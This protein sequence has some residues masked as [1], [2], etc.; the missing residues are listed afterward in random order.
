MAN[1]AKKSGTAKADVY[2]LV[3]EKFIEALK[4]GLIPWRKPWSGK[5]SGDGSARSYESGLAYS[6]LNQW[7]IYAQAEENCKGIE[8]EAARRERV[9]KISSGRFITFGALQKIEGSRII[10]GSKSYLVTFYKPY[11]PIDKETGKPAVVIDEDG[12]ERP[13]IIPMLKY[14]RVFSEFDCTGLPAE[15][16]EAVKILDP[17]AEAERVINNYVGRENGGPKFHADFGDKAFYSPSGD[18]VQVPR[19]EQYKQ[20]AEYYST[21]FHELVHST[22]HSSRCAREG[23]DK[24][25]HFGDSDY[26]REEL[27]AE[28]GA[29]MS[30]HRLQISTEGAFK[31]S[32]AYV[33]SWLKALQNDNKM[34]IWAAGR[35]EK[36]VK[37]IFG[38]RGENAPAPEPEKPKAE[39]TPEPKEEIKNISTESA[40][41]ALDTFLKEAP[42]NKGGEGTGFWYNFKAYFLSRD[43]DS[44]GGRFYLMENDDR[45]AE[46]ADPAKVV[47][48]AY[49]VLFGLD[50]PKA[51][52]K[53]EPKDKIIKLHVTVLKAEKI[54][55]VVEEIVQQE[56]CYLNGSKLTK[57]INQATKVT[58]T[59]AEMERGYIIETTKNG[60]QAKLD[61]K[62]PGKYRA[63]VEYFVK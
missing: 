2:T 14:Y 58:A 17:I 21:T 4:G 40:L 44:E 34:I 15:A 9:V 45:I 19:I 35:A 12:Q 38:E 32:V 16:P 39:S 7:L 49:S 10:K 6:Y 61:A 53:E 27:V 51:E 60:I 24:I 1:L 55:G 57:D 3:T 30:L 52:T 33:Q 22:G 50:A 29:A 62:Y 54:G 36:A 28:M 8:D 20:V 41:E 47:E 56:I 11:Q 23:F 13:K 25:V 37:W 31:N 43:I 59:F 63:E 42:L 48:K 46:D 26:S 5:Y 18:F